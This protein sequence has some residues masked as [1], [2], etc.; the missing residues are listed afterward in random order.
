MPRVMKRQVLRKVHLEPSVAGTEQEERVVADETF[1]YGL[2]SLCF[3]VIL[4]AV[5]I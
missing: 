3:E 5:C 1:L 4:A 2:G